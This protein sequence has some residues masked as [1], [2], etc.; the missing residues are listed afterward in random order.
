MTE[1]FIALFECMLQPNQIIYLRH[2]IILD[3]I[4]IWFPIFLGATQI[5]YYFFIDTLY[6]FDFFRLPSKSLGF[7]CAEKL[8][9]F[10]K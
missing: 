8:K 1:R 9:Y 3:Y 5:Y 6:I 4:F 10:R 7:E 2:K